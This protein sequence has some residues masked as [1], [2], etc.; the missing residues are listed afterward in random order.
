MAWLAPA[1]CFG[2][3]HWSAQQIFVTAKPGDKEAVAVFPFQNDGAAPVTITQIQPNCG[4]TTA[5]LAKRTYA[6][7]EAGE[8][9]AVFTFGDRLGLQEK[10]ILVTTDEPSAPPVSLVLRVNVPELITCT[11]RLLVWPKGAEPGEL[12][13]VITIADPQRIAAIE[14]GDARQEVF[15]LRIEPVEP[16]KS[17]RLFVRPVDL[18]RMTNAPI[19]YRARL[20][21][22]TVHPFLIYALVR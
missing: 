9:K 10:H 14:V 11:P 17:Y 8:I 4:C 12:S 1:L 15:K 5:D 21:D 13:A 19:L 22:G 2:A 3:L 18:S 7:G 16:G 6:P 20:Q